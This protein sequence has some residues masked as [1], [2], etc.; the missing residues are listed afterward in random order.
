MAEIAR[1]EGISVRGMRKYVRNL[2]PPPA[3]EATCE[4]IA[5]QPGRSDEAL[6]MSFDAM[7]GQ[8]PGS[9]RGFAGNAG[10]R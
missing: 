5:A 4:L 8:P 9:R 10:L 7:S 2:I 6:L 1:R 3:P